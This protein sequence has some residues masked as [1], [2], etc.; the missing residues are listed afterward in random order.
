MQLFLH[1]GDYNLKP[2]AD[3]VFGASE[4]KTP[5]AAPSFS[6]APEAGFKRE[7]G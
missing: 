7:L 6:V 2:S 3:Q 5:S 4:K 1:P